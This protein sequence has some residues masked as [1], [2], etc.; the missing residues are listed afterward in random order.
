MKNDND[1][2]TEAYLNEVKNIDKSS[3]P[4]DIM[5]NKI[6]QMSEDE[7]DISS[8]LYQLVQSAYKLG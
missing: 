2:I 5:V 3:N 6:I 1:F 8:A 4:I 7:K